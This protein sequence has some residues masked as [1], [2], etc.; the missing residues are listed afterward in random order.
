MT[1]PRRTAALFN[2]LKGL[3]WVVLALMA[4]ATL[5]AVWLGIT[6]WTFIAV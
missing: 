1:D 4:L 3:S 6:N 2:A 5:Y